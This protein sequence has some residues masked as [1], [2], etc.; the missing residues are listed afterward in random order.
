M[1]SVARE[2]W[3]Y[4]ENFFAG[5]NLNDDKIW[6][7]SGWV[8]TLKWYETRMKNWANNI[9]KIYELAYDTLKGRQNKWNSLN[10]PRSL[11][12]IKNNI[13][14]ISS[15]LNNINYGLQWKSGYCFGWWRLQ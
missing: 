7:L 9:I 6:F 4:P 10:L 11:A 1:E 8:A 12:V 13:S 5:N 2:E 14:D 15:Q 3:L